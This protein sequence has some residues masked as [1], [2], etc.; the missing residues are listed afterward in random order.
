MHMKHSLLFRLAEFINVLMVTAPFAFSWYAYYGE[1]LY[2]P[3]FRRG[4]WAMIALF[5]VLYVTYGKI[6]NAFAVSVSRIGE[7]VYSQILAVGFTDAI[8]YIV[9]F[10]LTKFIPN[11]MPLIAAFFMQIGLAAV[12]SVTA[13]HVYFAVFPPIRSAVIYDG[14]PELETLV[15]RYRMEKKFRVVLA[16]DIDACLADPGMLDGMEAV[17]L[18]GIHSHERNILLK[19]CMEKEIDV[20]VIPRLGDT[21]MS[22][23]ERTHMFHLPILHVGWFRQPAEYLLVK[24]IL[25]VV[26]SAAALLAVSPVML[27]TAVLIHAEDGGPV[28]YRQRR[29]TKGGKEFCLLKFRSMRPDAER[30]GEAVLSAGEDDSRVTQ[31]GRIIRRHR[32]DELPQLVNVL[33]GEMSLVGP[34][35]ERPE[36]AA[37]YE[38]EL[39]EFALRL[40][41]KAGL[42]GYAQVY[43]K[44]NTQPY[45]KLQM[46]LMY[47]SRPSIV[48]DLRILFLTVK[49]LFQKESTEGVSEDRP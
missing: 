24:R 21:I 11:P 7:I 40:K 39:P 13:H 15:G 34:R 17:F 46:D 29:L 27:A 33:K 30:D 36:I 28:F 45:D 22:G 49:V 16:K 6:Y 20:Y 41:G 3:F 10:L 25:D 1:R 44:Y 37:R 18:G 23:A 48:E 12:W 32:I 47:L 35:P 14:R 26:L 42:T 8:L 4:N 43:G 5:A 31:V 38:R 9:T 2:S 19:Y